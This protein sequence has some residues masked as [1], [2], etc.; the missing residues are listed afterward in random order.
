MSIAKRRACL[1]A[2]GLEG[3]IVAR[4]APPK[5]KRII[6]GRSFYKQ[7]TPLGFEF[8]WLFHTRLVT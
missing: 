3:I 8:N 4:A 2:D 7:V 6:G 5:T 1:D